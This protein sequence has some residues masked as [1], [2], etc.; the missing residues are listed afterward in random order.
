MTTD[1]TTN[2]KNNAYILGIVVGIIGLLGIGH[3]YLGRLQHGIIFLVV[4]LALTIVV[5]FDTLIGLL[6]F[7]VPYVISIVHLHM[8]IKHQTQQEADIQ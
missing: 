1:L 8:Y 2:R 3:M 5:F 7:T 6:L 4:G